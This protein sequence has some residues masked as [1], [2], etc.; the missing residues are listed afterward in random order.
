MNNL[1][2]T[3]SPTAIIIALSEGKACM[4][5]RLLFI[6]CPSEYFLYVP[7]GTF[8]ICDY[9]S[10]KN[11]PVK[12]LN[13]SL[14]DYREADTVLEDYL[15]LFQPTHIGLIFHWQETAEGVLWVGESIRSSYRHLKIITGG[16]TAG[17]FGK[18]LL[19]RCQFIDYV[20]KG[21]SEKP[22]ELLLK[23]TDPSEIPNLIHRDSTDIRSNPISYFIDEDTLSQIAF[24]ELTYLHD[25]ELYIKAIE[26][27]LGFPIFVGRGCEFNCVYCGGSRRSFTLH[28]ERINPVVR[29]VDS[30]I[31]DLKRLKD[32]TKT[33][34][35]C[36]ENEKGHIR[37]LFR[38]MLKERDLIKTFQLNYGAWQ[39]LDEE[40]LDLYK[41]LFL[42]DGNRKPQPLFELSPEVFDDDSRLKI[43]PHHVAYSMGDLR[44]N[45]SLISRHV[46]SDVKVSIFFSRY[47]D[48]LKT[49]AAMRRE[50][51]GIFRLQH[52]LFVKSLINVRVQYDHLSTD[53]ASHYW[54]KYVKHSGDFDTLMSA[55]RRLRAQEIYSFPVNNFFVYVPETLSEKEVFRC[56]L[57]IEIFKILR[58]NFHEM[59]HIL[60][61]CLG[62][63]MID[64]I[65]EIIAGEYSDRPGSI[66]T[67]LDI[68]ELLHF[69]KFYIAKNESFLSGIPFIEDLTAFCMKK[70]MC[71]RRQQP[72]KSLYQTD[73]PNINQAFISINEHDYLDLKTFLD[74]LS[75]EGPGNLTTD[76]TVFVFLS[77]EILSM[78]YITYR[79]TLKK[80][81]NQISLDDYYVLMRKK[82]LFTV[83]YHRDLI[84]KLFQHD[85]LY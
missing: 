72:Y 47:H 60:V 66:F 3:T 38:A 5:S 40:F 10:R 23:D 15:K 32:F 82:G 7:M 17:Y 70:A 52:N 81:E 2:K 50:I 48:A 41:H 85:V 46:G 42:L 27:K 30:V 63:T 34:Y 51:A 43:K 76:K 36:Y 53:I 28:S 1:T 69:L 6:N 25:Y 62:D 16:F 29:T 57:L 20:I 59:F 84:A 75:K 19:Q 65:E 37:E 18:N 31:S 71:Q 55:L 39:L 22:L 79:S 49:Y 35:I 8:G 74:K 54:E 11:I 4:Q 26:E 9:L 14:Y 77:D 21:D 67:S 80:F 78:S 44:E 73:R 45:I 64:L 68:Y 58:N 24:S 13:L 33:I 56:E 83:Q 61:D 12:I